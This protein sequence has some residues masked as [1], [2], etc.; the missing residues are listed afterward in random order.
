M[1][2]LDIQNLSASYSGYQALQGVNLH[3]NVGEIVGLC[4]PNKAGKSTLCK[5]LA[6]TKSTDAGDIFFNDQRINELTVA[7]RIAL[8]L[9]L[10]PERSNEP[11]DANPI[12]LNQD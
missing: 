7:R 6:G 9:T 10:C 11:G 4:G 5:C 8:G 12:Y 2:L 1:K 3:V